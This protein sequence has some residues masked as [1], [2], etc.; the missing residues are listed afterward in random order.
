MH[1][2]YAP[3]TH[4]QDISFTTKE[5][6]WDKNFSRV[7]SPIPSFQF[8]EYITYPSF[9]TFRPFLW[10]NMRNFQPW[11]NFKLIHIYQLS[12]AL[13]VPTRPFTFHPGNF[14]R[15]GSPCC[16]RAFGYLQ[17]KTDSNTHSPVSWKGRKDKTFSFL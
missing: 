15:F 9:N 2:G 5:E 17:E 1:V 16:V 6:K 4:S 8:W 12:S 11:A 7:K 10:P 13:E 3:C 14:F